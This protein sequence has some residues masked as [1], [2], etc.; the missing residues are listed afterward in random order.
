MCDT[1]KKNIKKEDSG[2]GSGQDHER[3]WQIYASGTQYAID[4]KY[5][6][7]NV[8]HSNKPGLKICY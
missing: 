7:N 8:S 5:E 3:S 4:E 2:Q 1:V 6:Q